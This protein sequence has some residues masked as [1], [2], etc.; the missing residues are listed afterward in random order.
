MKFRFAFVL[1]IAASCSVCWPVATHAADP[2]YTGIYENH[3]YGYSVLLPSGMAAEPYPDAVSN[4]GFVIGL[5][6]PAPGENGAPRNP[7][8]L[9]RS[10]LVQA[11]YALNEDGETVYAAAL[12]AVAL[13]IIVVGQWVIKKVTGTTTIG[14]GAS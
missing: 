12:S 13:L 14:G 4:Q 6:N 2:A 10:I 8:D 9:S 1:L 7:V 5:A 11:I 3:Q